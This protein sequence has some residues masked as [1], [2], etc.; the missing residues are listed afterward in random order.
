MG[1]ELSMNKITK[2]FRVESLNMLLAQKKYFIRSLL[3]RKK[4]FPK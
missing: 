4:L 3:R 1:E 2:A